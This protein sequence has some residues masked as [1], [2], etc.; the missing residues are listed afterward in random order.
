M[1]KTPWV[2]RV[3][4]ESSE[5]MC[6]LLR[7]DLGYARAALSDERHAFHDLLDK[8]HALKV[9]GATT[10]RTGLKPEPH[11]SSPSDRAIE[12]VVER[13]G[14]N[15]RLRRKLLQFRAQALESG[16]DDDAVADQIKHWRDPALNDD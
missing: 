1:F 8:Y 9:N 16:A 15:V 7:R 6:E 13:F 2:S 3:R 5:A 14:G 4:L 11:P 12:D 10:E